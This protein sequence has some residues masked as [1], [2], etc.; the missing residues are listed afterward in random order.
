MPLGSRQKRA[1]APNDHLSTNYQH[2][3]NQ[4][5]STQIAA[6]IAACLKPH[7]PTAEVEIF[8]SEEVSDSSIGHFISISAGDPIDIDI[9]QAVMVIARIE[10]V[11]WVKDEHG[12]FMIYF[13]PFKGDRAQKCPANLVGSDTSDKLDMHPL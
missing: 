9:V 1:I 2:G 7:C 13:V 6:A 4:M 8:S 12:E 5:S 10:F 11:K 3:E